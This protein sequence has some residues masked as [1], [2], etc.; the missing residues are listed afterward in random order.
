[1]PGSDPKFDKILFSSSDHEVVS[2]DIHPFFGMGE[3]TGKSYWKLNTSNLKE[4]NYKNTNENVLMDSRTLKAGYTSLG[5]WWTTRKT[6][7]SGSHKSIAKGKPEKALKK[8]RLHNQVQ[9]STDISEQADLRVEITK[10][11]D[12]HL[13]G[14]AIRART[15]KALNDE[16]G[17]KY[18]H[19]RIKARRQKNQVDV[20]TEEGVDTVGHKHIAGAYQRFRRKLYT[21]EEG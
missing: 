10:V 18:F 19:S 4:H 20:V 16:K 1:M 12:A 21:R 11:H 14:F 3:P 13:K 7:L 8:L 6:G 15:E 9:N 17:A 5:D 2:C